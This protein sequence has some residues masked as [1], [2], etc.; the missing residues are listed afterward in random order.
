MNLNKVIRISVA[1]AVGFGAIFAPAQIASASGGTTLSFDFNTAGQLD[2]D[3]NSFVSSGTVDQSVDGGIGN[4]GSISTHDADANA[5]FQPKARY[6]IGPVGSEY[7][8]ASYMKSVGNGGYSGFGFTA[9]SPSADTDTSNYGPFRPV[10]ALGISVH[11]GGF[12]FHNGSVDTNGSWNSDNSDITTITKASIGD[13]LN[14]G[15]PDRWYK[16]V[17]TIKRVNAAH[18]DIQV[19][20]FPALED[21]SLISQ[22]AAASFKMENQ[23]APSLLSAS[24]LHS[25]I[26]F[27]G[28]RVTNFDGFATTV[29]GGV[30]VEGA[31]AGSL[32][33]EP[34]TTS[35]GN[36]ANTSGNSDDYVAVYSSAFALIYVGFLILR[37]RRRSLRK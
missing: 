20:V 1:T 16:I 9:T 35:G 8:F 3:F 31:P 14:N 2:N 10:D 12:V 29:S 26:N 19:D 4:T 21:G 37:S 23:A 11:G 34:A 13:L 25:Y 24:N 17:F 33:G 18:F 36:L 27:S 22:S 5:V 30:V 7:S 6:S 15:S 32:S 28:Y